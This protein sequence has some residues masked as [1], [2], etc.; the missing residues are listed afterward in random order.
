MS[1]QAILSH[2]RSTDNLRNAGILFP[3]DA[4]S[5]HKI[6]LNLGAIKVYRFLEHTI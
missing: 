2:Y 1:S 4:A 5:I 3:T 6:S